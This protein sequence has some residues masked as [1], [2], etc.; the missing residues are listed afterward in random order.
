MRAI[1]KWPAGHGLPAG[2]LSVG[3]WQNCLKVKQ[4]LNSQSNVRPCPCA[5]LGHGLC[6]ADCINNGRLWATVC[7]GLEP[8]EFLFSRKLH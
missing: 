5:Y 1:R 6:A 4:T 8:S 7:T 2:L 3:L